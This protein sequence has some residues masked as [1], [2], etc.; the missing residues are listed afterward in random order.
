MI[1]Y[2]TILCFDTLELDLKKHLTE[3]RI[4]DILFIIIFF[5]VHKGIHVKLYD[6]F[7]WWLLKKVPKL[8]E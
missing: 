5:L 7:E 3:S 4:T 8:V 2:Q 6:R 1:R